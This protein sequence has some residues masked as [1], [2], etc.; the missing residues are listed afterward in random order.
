MTIYNLGSINADIFYDVPHIPR[1]GETLA[2]HGVR[3]GLGGKGANQ[4]VAVVRAGGS[5]KHIGA[6]GADGAWML[7]ALTELGVDT[8]LVA[9][10]SGES[11]HAIITVAQDGENA[12]TL[13]GGANLAILDSDLDN[14]LA[15]IGAGDWLILQNETNGQA[16]AAALARRGGARVV[17]SAAPFDVD[18]VRAVLD[19]VDILAMNQ[20][21]AE[22]LVAA[23]GVSDIVEIPVPQVLVTL[24]AKGGKLLHT[25]TGENVTVSGM[26][27]TPVDT[28]GAGDTFL[29]YFIAALD[30]GMDDHAAL[31]LANRA[32]AVKVT[33]P[34]TASAIPSRAMVDEFAGP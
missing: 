5:V 17:Y 13:V 22:A 25:A 34:G 28:T 11:G 9:R 19:H 10:G 12:I 31:T 16:H 3:R 24:G 15:G 1:P 30:Q 14:A 33:R 23:L 7:A 4:S 26:P 21:E 18:A 2:A 27:V 29:G 8:S 20:G 6:V 32:A